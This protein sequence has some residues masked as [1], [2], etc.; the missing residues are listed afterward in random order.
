MPR[1]DKLYHRPDNIGEEQQPQSED[2]VGHHNGMVLAYGLN[3][4]RGIDTVK[5]ESHLSHVEPVEPWGYSGI[6]TPGYSA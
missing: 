2:M 4:H 6:R 5:I 1:Q 3:V